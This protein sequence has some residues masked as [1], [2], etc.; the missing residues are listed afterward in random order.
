VNSCYCFPF[1]ATVALTTVLYI[2]PQ[3]IFETLCFL[4]FQ[5][6]VSWYNLRKEVSVKYCCCHWYD[7]HTK[8]HENLSVL[9]IV[10]KILLGGRTARICWYDGMIICWYDGMVVCWYDGVSICWYDGM[11]I[12]WYDGMV[13]CWYD[14][15]IICWYYGIIVCWYDGMI[16]S[17]YDG[18][19]ICWY[20]VIVCWYD[21]MI[22]F[23]VD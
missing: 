18:M 17:W 10:I 16:V 3:T 19:I 20:G 23:I 5:K 1:N 7:V 6:L 21:G 2:P 22:I 4:K 12:C 8:F 9:S 14:G 13:V 11:I 15:M